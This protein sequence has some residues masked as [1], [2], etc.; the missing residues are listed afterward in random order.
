MAVAAKIGDPI[1]T[2]IKTDAR[3]SGLAGM[4]KSQQ[5][6]IKN[7]TGPIIRLETALEIPL[8]GKPPPAPPIAHKQ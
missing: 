1:P 8:A 2:V 4:I 5:H 7:L 3:G 6:Q